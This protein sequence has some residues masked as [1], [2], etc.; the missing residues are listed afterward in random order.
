MSIKVNMI[1]PNEDVSTLDKD[2]A[3]N[4]QRISQ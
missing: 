4:Y 2:L 3:E 1:E